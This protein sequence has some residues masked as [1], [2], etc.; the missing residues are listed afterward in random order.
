[1]RKI[2]RRSGAEGAGARVGG[3]EAA[4]ASFGNALHQAHDAHMGLHV[5]GFTILRVSS[6][7]YTWVYT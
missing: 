7:N 4:T 1:V 3:D 2:I 6:L 5:E